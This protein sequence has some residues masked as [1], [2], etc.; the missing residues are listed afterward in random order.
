MEEEEGVVG[1]A[2]GRG[3]GEAEWRP[4]W[5]G[6][7]G[8]RELGGKVNENHPCKISRITSRTAPLFPP[9]QIIKGGGSKGPSI[10]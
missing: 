8:R 7:A 3:R 1:K 4:G 9:P 6:K 5:S 10:E 2:R